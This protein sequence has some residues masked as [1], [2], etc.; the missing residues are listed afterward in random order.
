VYHAH[1]I[2]SFL[3]PII[4]TH[5]PCIFEVNQREQGK[6]IPADN[7]RLFVYTLSNGAKGFYP[8]LA[9]SHYTLAKSISGYSKTLYFLI[10]V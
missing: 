10:A 9:L 7:G 1:G 4:E 3:M 5:N 8:Y 6:F 2:P